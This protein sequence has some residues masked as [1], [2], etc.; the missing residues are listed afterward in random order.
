MPRR[1]VLIPLLGLLGL[2]TSSLAQAADPGSRSRYVVVLSEGSTPVAEVAREAAPGRTLDR[3]YRHALRGFAVRLSAGEAARLRSAPGVAAVVPDRRLHIA[4]IQTGATWGLDRIDQRKLPRDTTYSYTA[5]AAGVTAYVIDTGI[6]DTHQ[7]FA[8]R[9]ATGIDLVDGLPATDCNGHGTHVA[10]TIGGTRFGV[11]KGIT[12]VPVRVLDCFGGGWLSDIVAGI[13]W[14]T[15][16][17]APGEPAVAN[18][19]LGGPGVKVLDKAVK[20]SIADGITYAVAA[21]NSGTNACG[22]SP[23]RVGRAITVSATNLK[24]VRP[25]WA[26]HG[27][28]VD[29]FAPGVSVTSAWSYSDAATQTIGGTSMAAPHVAGVAALYLETHPAAGPA[30]VRKALYAMTTK[31]AVVSAK[32]LNKHLLFTNL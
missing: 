10:G 16:D 3:V 14:V 27:P 32:S 18:M 1:S 25:K 13:D 26:N 23:A 12:L 8:G 9:V 11:A 30:A 28:C 22:F 24:D 20:A 29:W 7:E 6:R 5:T 31:K 2:L 4:A 21:G 19:S 15:L 17:H